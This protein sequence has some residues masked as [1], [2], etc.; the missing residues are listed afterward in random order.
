MTNCDEVFHVVVKE[1][2]KEV[3]QGRK[4]M[5]FRLRSVGREIERRHSKPLH[6][7]YKTKQRFL[8]FLSF[9][10]LFFNGLSTF[11]VMMRYLTGLHN[12][13]L[14]DSAISPLYNWFDSFHGYDP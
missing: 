11:H 5:P 9:V 4:C 3:Q 7:I 1:W 14:T 13:F 2:R 8:F 6:P 10:I 12:S